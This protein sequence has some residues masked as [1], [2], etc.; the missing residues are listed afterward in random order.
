MVFSSLAPQG[1]LNCPQAAAPSGTA[2]HPGQVWSIQQLLAVFPEDVE[3]VPA[4][5]VLWEQ[6]PNTDFYMHGLLSMLVSELEEL[7]QYLQETA[8]TTPE[9][10]REKWL[11]IRATDLIFKELGQ[12]K[13]PQIN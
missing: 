10:I 7:H 1:G 9:T 3:D 8:E 5:M 12:H 4:E 6:C 2:F 11:K 13:K